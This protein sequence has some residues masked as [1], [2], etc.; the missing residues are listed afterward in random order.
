MVNARG[1]FLDSC[2]LGA[3]GVKALT[4]RAR[5]TSGRGVGGGG[6]VRALL[7]LFLCFALFA[8]SLITYYEEKESSLCW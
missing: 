8:L 5:G 1:K 4:L 7:L 6:R 3:G 2:F